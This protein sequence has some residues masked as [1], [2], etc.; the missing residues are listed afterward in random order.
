MNSRF[1]NLELVTE[2]IFL[3]NIASKYLNFRTNSL[4]MIASASYTHHLYNEYLSNIF[5][6]VP[7]ISEGFIK[8]RFYNGLILVDE[9]ET[10]CI[11]RACSLFNCKYACVQPYS[12][13]HANLCIY[14]ALLNDGDNV[15]SMFLTSGGHLTH[16]S[17][18]SASSKHLNV[19]HYGLDDNYNI[20]YDQVRDMALNIKPKMIV[21]G[22]SS[23]P[24]FVNFKCFSEIAKSCGAYLLADISH[25][26]GL[27][28]ANIHESPVCFADIIMTTF[29]KTLLGPKGAMI[30]TNN[31]YI[32]SKISRSV[33][34]RNSGTQDIGN[35][36]MKCACL[37]FASTDKFR[38]IM[39][40][41]VDNAKSF[42]NTLKDTELYLTNTDN[43]IVL[44]NSGYN[45]S[46]IE[47]VNMMEECNIISNINVINKRF[48]QS[49]HCV[50]IGTTCNTQI[51]IDV[52]DHCNI[53]NLLVNLSR[54]NISIEDVK[55]YIDNIFN[56]H[57][58]YNLF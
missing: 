17:K 9:L 39:Q 33:F 49:G 11:N 27:V 54:K 43:H 38:M 45:F 21:C 25:I 24:Y 48:N 19:Y 36:F 51:G 46:A 35:L 28:V 50:R 44:F 12:G 52:Q 5:D 41:V 30:L 3:K 16:F 22:Y 47:F 29:Y 20:N 6:I 23:Y 56:K 42:C 53:A 58:I 15:L 7:P 18:I 37:G 31:E 55:K 1:F 57:N 26:S 4:C 13:T 34:P 32:Y 2:D 40:N 10:E 8:N 14:D